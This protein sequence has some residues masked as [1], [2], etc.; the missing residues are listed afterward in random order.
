[1]TWLSLLLI[2]KI[3]ATTILVAVPFL[4]F[5]KS[6]LEKLTGMAGSNPVFFRMYGVAIV[7]LLVGYSFGIPSAESGIFPWGVTA[8]G[9]VSN[10][11]AAALLLINVRTSKANL[12]LGSLFTLIALG[13]VV[14]MSMS[15]WALQRAW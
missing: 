15:Q 7:A 4:F 11:G 14:T 6:S 8:M 1:M 2:I 3:F 9:T 13:L 10:S 5:P 12:L